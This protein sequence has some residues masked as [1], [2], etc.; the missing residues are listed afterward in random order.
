MMLLDCP[1]NVMLPCGKKLRE[2]KASVLLFKRIGAME[3]M[4]VTRRPIYKNGGAR[5]VHATTKEI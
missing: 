5:R 4:E 1:K 3:N 2:Y